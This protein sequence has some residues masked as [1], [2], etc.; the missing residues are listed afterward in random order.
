MICSS[1]RRWQES[2]HQKGQNAALH[3][4]TH[5]KNKV[6]GGVDTVNDLAGM[7]QVSEDGHPT[8]LTIAAANSE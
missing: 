7:L 1:A 2:S 8:N 3:C 6:M 4:N 5:L